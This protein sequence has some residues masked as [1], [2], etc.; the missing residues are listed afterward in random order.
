MQYGIIQGSVVATQKVKDLE[1]IALKVLHHGADPGHVT[2]A[3]LRLLREAQIHQVIITPC[4]HRF[5]NYRFG[6]SR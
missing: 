5:S 1:G 3:L 4:T 2:D 6:A